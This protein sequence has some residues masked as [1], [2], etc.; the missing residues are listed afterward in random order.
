MTKQEEDVPLKREYYH[1][2]GVMPGKKRFHRWWNWNKDSLITNILGPFLSGQIIEGKYYK[3]PC[4]VNM[5]AIDHFMMYR[6]SYRLNR[7]QIKEFKANNRIGTNCTSEFM[8]EIRF[9]I[10]TEQAQSLMQK[11]ML[12][13]EQQIFVIM[14]LGDK[15]LDSAY[16]GVVRPLGKKFGYRVLRVDEVENSGTITSQIIESI[17]KS[18]VVYADLTGSR[19]NCYY[20]TG[21]AYAT[22]RELILAIRAGEKIHFDLSVNR[23]IIWETENQLRNH[24]RRRLEAIEERR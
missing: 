11:L 21:V 15:Y 17:A 1:C 22:G 13:P 18:A 9:D 24:L 5:T 16:E 8:G 23:F 14:K 20:E 6:T 10:A 2:V 3:R 4:L 7:T 12:P 19:P